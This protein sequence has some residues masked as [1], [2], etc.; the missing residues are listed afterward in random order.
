MLSIRE[1]YTQACSRSE[2]LHFI[3]DEEKQQLQNRLKKMYLE[4]EK[5]CCSHN[6]KLV[7]AYGTV[8]GALRHQGFIP[9][10]DDLDVLMPREDFNKLL[11]SYSSEFPSNLQL[12]GPNTA[13]GPRNCFFQLIDTS[14]RL[15][16]AG[17]KDVP[18]NGIYVDIFI[19]DNCP[20]NKFHWR[21]RQIVANFLRL[22]T[23]CVFDV[24][25][26]SEATRKL[27]CS[28]KSGRN[29]YY[30]R[31]TIGRVFSFKTASKWASLFDNFIAYHK[32]TG[33]Y[34]VTNGGPYDRNNMPIEESFYFPAKKYKFDDIEI[35]VPNQIEKYCEL[36][37][38]DWKSIPP[39]EKRNQHFVKQV[40]F[41]LNQ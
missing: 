35:N 38:G 12:Y 25:N 14:T 34:S 28:T 26:D 22:I 23:K 15:L 32:I 30:I 21:Y 2:E 17:G 24:E 37:Y 20:C 39:V 10:D 6:L 8:L 33:Y 41:N 7:S 11:H 27:L 19:L 18:K 5:V 36:E 16:G 4:L 1:A 13:N 40:K 31:K 9:W 3:S 29:A